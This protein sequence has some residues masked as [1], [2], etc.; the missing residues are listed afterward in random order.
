[1]RLPWGIV[2]KSYP[3][4]IQKGTHMKSI[5]TLVGLLTAILLCGS[6]LSCSR[7]N[8]VA[9]GVDGWKTLDRPGYSIQYPPDWELNQ[10]GMMGT[11]FVLL[12]AKA[13][14]DDDFREN[15]N[16]VTEP[17]DM[18]LEEYI[19]AMNAMFPRV[20]LNYVRVS[21]ERTRDASG[22]HYE[23]VSAFDMG[24]GRIKNRQHYWVAD[25]KAYALTWTSSVERFDDT[26]ETGE[27]ILKSFR[28]K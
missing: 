8:E 19:E 20:F 22:E 4:N 9:H 6:L 12:A 25:G 21:L 10:S 13:P 7:E 14:G 28:I 15:V 5:K 26:R 2:L 18:D 27:K 24:A 11:E 1:M 3:S 16:L 17:A 23:M